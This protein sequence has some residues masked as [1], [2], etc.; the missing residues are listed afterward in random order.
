M[1]APVRVLI[2]DDEPLARQRLRVLAGAEPGVTVVAECATGRAAAAALRAQ[3]VDVAFL[4]VEMPD[5]DGFEAV[6]GAERGRAPAVV[7]VTAYE[8][9]ARRAFDV[10]A[11]DYLLKPFDAARFREALRRACARRAAAEG[12]RPVERLAV[13]SA[14][15]VSVVR[16]D[17][18][19]YAEACGN[20]VELHC[21][22]RRHLIRET[23]R[24]LEARLDP[25]RFV[26][27]H[28]SCLVNIDRVREMHP[29]FHG[30]W[31]VVLAGGARLTMSRTY[32]ERVQRLLG[33]AR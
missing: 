30:D 23:M 25:R 21:E 32:R 11:V 26:R 31:L 18:L 9:Y 2:A 7:F 12:P 20:Y 15:R 13:R 28:R 22:G 10:E 6:R 24:G 1:T 3:D 17:E 33:A 14:S 29:L 16:V 27:I 4:D 19:D 8:A 5:G